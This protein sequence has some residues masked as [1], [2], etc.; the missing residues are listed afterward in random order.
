MKWFMNM[1]IASKLIIGFVLVAIIT[2]TVGIVGITSLKTANK[3]STQLYVNMTV[4]ISQLA[5]INKDFQMIGISLRDII[6]ET[7]SQKMQVIADSINAERADM[8]KISN[9][10]EKTIL[11]DNMKAAF[12]DFTDKKNAYDLQF[13]NALRLAESNKNVE[14]VA[15]I[16]ATGAEGIATK[17]LQNS[18]VALI[19][20]KLADAKAKSDTNTSNSNNSNNVM[21]IFIIAGVLIAIGLGIFLSNIISRPIK[22][23]SDAADKLA[24]GDVD[25]TILVKTKDEIGKLMGS[26]SKMI[27]NI[28]SQVIS[29]EKIAGGDLDYVISVKSEKDLLGKKLIEMQNTMKALMLETDRKSVV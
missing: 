23:L 28:R 3:S 27:E 16:S 1:K 7:N 12:K 13:D 18:I 29:T 8:Q 9:E 6:I 21:M 15:L 5:D 4:P 26:F 2:A 14:A 10:Y 11:S 24:L 20:L 17:A 19:N 25:I 22:L